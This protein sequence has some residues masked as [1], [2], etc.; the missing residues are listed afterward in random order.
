MIGFLLGTVRLIVEVCGMGA[1]TPDATDSTAN[2]R[3]SE[4][5][6]SHHTYWHI[7]LILFNFPMIV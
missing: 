1:G 2:S 4:P 5:Y 7:G 3:R 6:Q